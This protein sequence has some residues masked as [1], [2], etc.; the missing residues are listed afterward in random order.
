VEKKD[1]RNIIA[2]IRIKEPK[3]AIKQVIAARRLPSGDISFSTLT[4]KARIDL[5]K[6]SDWLRAVAP[7]AEVRRTTFAVFV[8]GVR[9]QGVNTNDQIRTIKDIR[10]ENSQLHLNLEITRILWLKQTITEQK[11]YS[12]LILETANPETANRIIS[13]GLIH[14]G[15]L[16]TSV[17]FLSEGKVTRYYNCQGYGHIAKV[18]RGLTACGECAGQHLSEACTKGPERSRKCA[19]CKGNHRAGSQKCEIEMK[20]RERAGYARNQAYNLYQCTS[21]ISYSPRPTTTAA[22]PTTSTQ[23]LPQ[24]IGNGWQQAVKGRRGRPSQLSQAARDPTQ[25]RIPSTQISKRKERDFTSPTPPERITR[26]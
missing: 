11:R 8:H 10:E 5:E 2:A 25:T 14:E 22:I 16:K 18:Y 6:S 7:T 1:M 20:E 24:P 9:V 23:V 13:Q 26:T 12:S 19:A 21:T 17:R 4:E 15:E 3:E